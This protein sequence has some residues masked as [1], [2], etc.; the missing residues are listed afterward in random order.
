MGLQHLENSPTQSLN[1]S[2]EFIV[3]LNLRSRGAFLN[4]NSM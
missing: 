2:V 4:R 1:Y 3:M